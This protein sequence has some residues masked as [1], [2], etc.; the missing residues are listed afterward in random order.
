MLKTGAEYLESLNDGRRVFIS[1]ERV[2]NVATHRVLGVAA[3]TVA[4]GYDLAREQSSLFFAEDPDSG[5]LVNRF[6]VQP[7][8]PKD[9]EYRTRMIH[10]F[11]HSTGGLPFGKDIGSDSLFAALVVARAMG[12][13]EY[14]E[15]V[16]T[17]L[18]ELRKTNRHTAG[19]ITC[20][21]GDRS[22][23]PAAQKHPDYYLHVVDERKDG[24]VVKGAKIH[25]TNAP[26]AHELIVVPTR[27]MRE[28]EA[29]Y[30]V[31]FAI[32]AN[33]PGI[34][35]IA[36]GGRGAWGEHEFHPDRPIG[37]LT[38]AMIV[39]D[40]VFVPRERIFMNGEWRHSMLLAYTFATFH[41]YTAI[42]YKVPDVEVMAGTA[43]AMAKYNGLDRVGHIKDKLAEIAAYVETLRA[44]AKAAAAD[45]VMYGD[46]AVPN[47]LVANMA[48][49]HFA[50]GYH[51][52][53]KK[54]QDIS[55]GILAT[56]P[57]KRDWDNPEI[58][59]YLEHYL[60][61]SADHSTLDR[62]KMIHETMRVVASREAAYHEVITV[63]AEGSMAAQKMMI[64]NEA[65]LDRY[66]TLAK[67]AAGIE[68]TESLSKIQS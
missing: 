12:N 57:D 18:A 10:S 56:A 17:V 50:T 20:V 44:L 68:P 24:I 4:T 25:I 29:E 58:H 65:P 5:E 41:R 62:L 60:G 40:D 67:I 46:I 22:K 54:I 38:E 23:E 43:V 27:Q 37:Q 48:K 9:L 35:F 36:R 19:A 55:G 49:L 14:E 33:T 39:F 6:F 16:K 11:L 32:P 63:H 31:S 3:E 61:G 8:T 42:S 2:E 51:E 7:R 13:R 1:G 45:P 52:F 28:N 26:L 21:K 53:V 34:T 59:D 66:E 30:A 15:N 64:L 47:P